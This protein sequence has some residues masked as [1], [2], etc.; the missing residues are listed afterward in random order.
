MSLKNEVL[1][2]SVWAQREAWHGLMALSL[3]LGVVWILVSRIPG[4]TDPTAAPPAPRAGFRAPDFT[5]GTLDGETVTLSDLQGQPVLINFW[6]TWCPPC[7]AELPAIQAAYERYG[8]QGLP[9]RG[10]QTGLVVLAV[11]MAE[12]ADA[13]AAFAQRFGLGFPIP[14]DRDG[15]VATQYRVR[16]IPTSFFVDR[17]GV[18]RSVFTG[19]MNGPLIED[20]LAQVMREVP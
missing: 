12:S 18:V 20:R 7:R 15:Q 1:Q 4:Q 17:E 8:D 19:P 11:D 6:A 5:L 13:V 14:L 16:A 2:P 9:V 10:T 3:I